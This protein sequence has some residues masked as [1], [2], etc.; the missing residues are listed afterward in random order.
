VSEDEVSVRS[1][2]DARAGLLEKIVVV[3]AIQVTSGG[4]SAGNALSFNE[5]VVEL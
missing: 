2:A 1:P 5:L 3:A 4:N